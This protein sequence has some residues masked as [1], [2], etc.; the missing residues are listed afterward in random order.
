MTMQAFTGGY[1]GKILRV[2]LTTRQTSVEELKDNEVEMLLGGRGIAARMYY[3]EIGADTKPFDEGNKLFFVTGPM[4]GVPLPSTTKFQLATKSPETGHYLCSNCGGVFG[5]QLKQCG[6]DALIIEGRADNWTYL[7]INDG[8]VEF[9]DASA[10][11]GLSTDKAQAFLHEAIGDKNA[12]TMTIGPAAEKLVRL[13]YI[14]VDSRAF[15]RGGPGAV[16]G[17]KKLKG[18]AVRGTGEVPLADRGRVNEIRKAAIAELRT[19]RA[20]HTRLGTMQYIK[21]LNDLGCMPTRNFQ[22]SHFEDCEP[23]EADAMKADFYV[24]NYACYRCPVACGKMCEVKE[25]PHA[26]AHA[27]TEFETVGL[28]GPCCGVS[29]FAA[30]V[31]ANQL[32]D[33]IG[34]DTISVGNSV[35]LTMEL[36]ERG[37]ITTEDTDGIEANFGSGEAL[38]EIIRLVGERRGIG[39][40]LAEGMAEVA[41][42]KPEWSWYIMHVKGMPFAAY[43][44]RGF[45]GNAL[46]KGTS[47]RG[48]CHNV[49]G[50]SIRAELLSGDHDR[51]A[52]KGK[53][54]LIMSIQDNRAYVDSLGLC[55]VVRGSMAFSAS[56]AGDTMEAVTGYGFTP[57]LLEIGERIYSLER[58]ILNREGIVR[59]D[60]MLPER[61]FKEAIPSG[62]CEGRTLTREQYDIML[63]EYYQARGWDSDG[64]VT[65]ETRERLGL[66]GDLFQTGSEEQ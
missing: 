10:M 17:S 20:D 43:D 28:F 13:S 8:E 53:G 40:L 16:M 46:T 15:G 36:F 49:G 24:R 66:T 27:R 58:M 48:A 44:P 18:I 56:P 25:G 57:K 59:A 21:K 64:V 32:A 54:P 5:P 52:L 26:G 23:V 41:R 1:L 65:P 55:T 11:V 7:T 31:A 12:G 50:W 22:T 63:D 33:E 37:L 38:I 51:F 39:D 60:D 47:S 61:I 2:N 45:Y 9:C 4:T 34:L 19:T 3:D 14:G 35:S 29:D 42:R 6:L 62:P 30:I